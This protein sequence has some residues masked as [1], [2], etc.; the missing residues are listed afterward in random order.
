MKLHLGCGDVKIGGYVNV[1]VRKYPIY[2]NDYRVVPDVIDDMT[3]LRQFTEESVSVIY[4]CH[5]LEH[6][7]RF[8]YKNAMKRWY[9]LLKK[10]GI[11]RISV[12]DMQ[13][14]CEYYVETGDL[15]SIRGT[16]YG[17]QTYKENFHFWGWDFKELKNDLEQVGFHDVN[18]YDWSKTEHSHVKDWSRDYLPRHDK[19]GKELS[20]EKWYEGKLVSLNVE[21]RK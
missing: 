5:A 13:S 6:L 7:T 1:D 3:E 11:L 9:R 16:I 4:V 10:D 15:N 12:P 14:L 20:D 8:Q 21:A 17:G 2:R 18:K 19:D